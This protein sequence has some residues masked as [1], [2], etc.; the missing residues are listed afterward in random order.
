MNIKDIRK[1]ADTVNEISLI[2]KN[3]L[4]FLGGDFLLSEIYA[5]FLKHEEEIRKH[6]NSEY[7][8]NHFSR[9]IEIATTVKDKDLFSKIVRWDAGQDALLHARLAVLIVKAS[10]ELG[11]EIPA[12]TNPVYFGD[13][14]C[15]TDYLNSYN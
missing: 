13:M 2:S 10:Y 8:A 14:F 11:F 1:I 3:E 5:D 6:F 15:N 12:D 4:Y 7:C 9:F